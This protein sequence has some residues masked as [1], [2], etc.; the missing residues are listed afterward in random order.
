[1]RRKVHSF[2]VLK[3]S[4]ILKHWRASKNRHHHLANKKQS[5]VWT[6]A[7]PL[8]LDM[9]MVVI[10]GT[11]MFLV[12]V[13]YV[14]DQYLI[15]QIEAAHW[16]FECDTTDARYYYGHCMNVSWPLQICLTCTF[17]MMQHLKMP[18]HISLHMALLCFPAFWVKNKLS[19]TNLQNYVLSKNWKL[20]EAR[21]EYLADSVEESLV[22]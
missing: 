1:M 14:H 2:I 16:T 5:F 4:W 15:K 18:K 13:H 10:F 12:W 3:Q 8:F 9:P 17:Q 22:F 19:A 6:L 20:T 7:C 11:F 21:G